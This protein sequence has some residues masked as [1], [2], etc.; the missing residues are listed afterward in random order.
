M[1]SEV[2]I[3]RGGVNSDPGGESEGR[4]GV[5][6]G[7]SRD[8]RSTRARNPPHFPVLSQTTQLRLG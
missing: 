4:V 3:L 1:S 6:Q 7:R 2:F 5:A 8:A